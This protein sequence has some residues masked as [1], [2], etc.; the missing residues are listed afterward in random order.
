VSLCTRDRENVATVRLSNPGKLNAID[1]AMW[2]NL[3]EIVAE[4][5]G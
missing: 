3:A 5:S 1:F 4:L 2:Q